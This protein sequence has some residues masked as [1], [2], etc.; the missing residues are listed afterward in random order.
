MGF[1]YDDT[2]GGDTAARAVGH[3]RLRDRWIGAGCPWFSASTPAPT[4]WDA[5]AQLSVFE[6][7]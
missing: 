7:P 5:A 6:G 3:R 1:G 2:A 4:G